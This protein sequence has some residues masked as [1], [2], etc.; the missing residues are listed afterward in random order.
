MTR[1]GKPA[2]SAI[3]DADA[4]DVG[5]VGVAAVRTPTA[6]KADRACWCPIQNMLRV[7]RACDL[8]ALNW[9]RTILDRAVLKDVRVSAEIQEDLRVPD[10]SKLCA[11]AA[12]QARPAFALTSNSPSKTITR[13]RRGRPPQESHP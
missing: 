9:P 10:A 12:A 3:I 11:Q 7:R 6:S 8:E 1:N 13:A 2:T 4:A 5:D